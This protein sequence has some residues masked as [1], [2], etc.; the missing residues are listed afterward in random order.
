VVDED[1][2]P[3]L[4]GTKELPGAPVDAAFRL[5]D[6]AFDERLVASVYIVPFVGEDCLMA[7]FDTGDWALLGGTLEPGE[8]SLGALE[9]ELLE[10]AGARL[11]AYTP[12][13]LVDCHSRTAPL[14]THLPHPDYQCVLGHG[15]AEVVQEPT[16][17]EDGEQTI[18]VT[19]TPIER[20]AECFTDQGQTWEAELYRLAARLRNA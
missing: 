13:A 9:R 18:T 11:L 8:S 6:R 2:F 10:E 19:T 4:F 16:S 12:F 15:E 1:E 7:R 5:L 17:P 3:V 20:A 14:R